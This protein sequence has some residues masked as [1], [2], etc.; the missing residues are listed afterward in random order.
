VEESR[1]CSKCNIE[2]PLTD[3]FFG[4][5][6]KNKAR[7]HTECRVCKKAYMRKW[8]QNKRAEQEVDAKRDKH[9][10]TIK[11]LTTE[12]KQQRLQEAYAYMYYQAFGRPISQRQL[13][14]IEGIEE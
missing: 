1:V 3:E 5:Q 2:K 9:M 10:Y 13:K 12:E 11:E 4:P 6:Q 7:L 8:Q 14:E